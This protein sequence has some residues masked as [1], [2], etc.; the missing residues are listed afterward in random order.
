MTDSCH[1]VSSFFLL[2][3]VALPFS[4]TV[5]RYLQEEAFAN[6]RTDTFYAYFPECSVDFLVEY[7]K[8][9]MEQFGWILEHEF[10][11]IDGVIICFFS[12]TRICFVYIYKD[13]IN[14]DTTKKVMLCIGQINA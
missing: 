11:T 8:N 10:Y 7:Y 5:E 12:V 3:N 1:E 2:E 13:G 4:S 14:G 6:G 9:T